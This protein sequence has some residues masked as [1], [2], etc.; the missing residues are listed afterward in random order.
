MLNSIFLLLSLYIL[1]NYSDFNG[2][3]MKVLECVVHDL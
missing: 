2:Y 1:I 3:L